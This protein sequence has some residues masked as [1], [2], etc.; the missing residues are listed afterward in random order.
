[1]RI[2]LPMNAV[3]PSNVW[4]KKSRNKTEKALQNYINRKMK[5]TWSSWECLNTIIFCVHSFACLRQYVLQFLIYAL[6]S[7]SQFKI[8]L[9]IR[10]VDFW[11]HCISK[12][13]IS[14]WHFCCILQKLYAHNDFVPLKIR[15]FRVLSTYNTQTNCK[16]TDK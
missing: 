5:Y 3:Q 8:Q 7:Y 14:Y 13:L 15:C 4:H 2:H 1:M 12:I 16:E 9:S 11:D 6:Y 10:R